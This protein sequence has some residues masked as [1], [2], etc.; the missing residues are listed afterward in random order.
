M[1]RKKSPIILTVG[2]LMIDHYLWGRCDRISPEAPVQ[3]VD[4][5]DESQRLGGACNVMS[6]L[7]ALDAQVL[8]CG[9]LGEDESSVLMVSMLKEIGVN[10]DGVFK[11]IGRKTTKKSRIIA[12]HQQVARVDRESKEPIGE[13]SKEKIIKYISS[14]LNEFDL[15]LISDYGKG[16]VSDELAQEII[17]VCK[18]GNK[19]VLVDPKGKDYSKYKGAYLITPNRKEAALASGIEISDDSSLRRA[20]FKL[21]DSLDLEYAIITLSEDGMAI[22]DR[23][24]MIK[25]PTVAK[26]VYD[27]TGA[28]DTVLASL[29]YSL[30]QEG[31]I[32]DACHFANS[33]AAV[34][35]GKVGSATASLEEISE[36]QHSIKQGSLEAKIKTRDEI[37]GVVDRLKKSSKKIVFT[38][39]CFDILHSGHV[40]YLHKAKELGDVLIIG[41]NN[42]TSVERLKGEGRPINQEEDRATVLSALESVDFVVVFDEDTPLELIKVITPDVLVKGADYEGKE[43]VGSQIASE[44]VLI[45]FVEGRSTTNIIKKIKDGDR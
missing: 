11:E 1:D 12:N 36:Y 16:V 41:L 8:A 28:G 20:G 9:V 3:V 39:G 5:N 15:C 4:I 7:R 10:V 26:E 21:R 43:V 38:N 30:A 35:V 44:T 27:V 37:R 23:Q 19:K 24:N 2:D 34:V 18:K 40:K 42:D 6:N 31:D 33:A 29:G 45:E 32:I 17:S 22:F 25:I 14:K 13:G